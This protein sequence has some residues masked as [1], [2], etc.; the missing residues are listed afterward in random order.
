MARN[1]RKEYDE[2][3]KQPEQKKNRAARNKARRDAGLKKGDSR[4]VDHKKPL[5]KGGTNSLDN[6]RIVARATNRKKGNK[7]YYALKEEKKR[8]ASS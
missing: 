4:E 1:Y 7:D 8:K 3:H 2:Y 6:V 5:S